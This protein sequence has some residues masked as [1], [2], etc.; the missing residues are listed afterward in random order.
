MDSIENNKIIV[1]FLG[2][3]TIDKRMRIDNVYY[4]KNPFIGDACFDYYYPSNDPTLGTESTCCLS[5]MK[6]NL[7]W[8]WI[9]GVFCKIE[10]L[11]Y[12]ISIDTS[13]GFCKYVIRDKNNKII[14]SEIGHQN[15]L[16]CAYNCIIIFIKYIN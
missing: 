14:A 9:E 3:K 16:Q 4:L 12:S 10:D 5:K 13:K 7:D 11:G 6:F 15:K 8:R 1:D 2:F